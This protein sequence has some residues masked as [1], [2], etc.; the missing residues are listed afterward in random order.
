MPY[1]IKKVGTGYSVINTQTG[2][3]HARHTTLRK[4]E[5]QIKLLHM[6]DNVS[7]HRGHYGMSHKR[8]TGGV[9]PKTCSCGH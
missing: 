2:Q 5:A 8:A 1:A 4:A 3:V 9:R 7:S 6:I